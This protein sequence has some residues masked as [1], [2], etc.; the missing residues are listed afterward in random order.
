MKP[1]EERALF[2]LQVTRKQCHFR[3]LRILLA[4]LMLLTAV[5]SRIKNVGMAEYL[6]R[7]QER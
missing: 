4:A 5:V 2:D 6:R 7:I 3:P 1:Y